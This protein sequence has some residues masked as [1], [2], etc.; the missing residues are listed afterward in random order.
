MV[1]DG[2]LNES[3]TTE[4][5]GD[6]IEATTTTSQLKELFETGELSKLSAIDAPELNI[7]GLAERLHDADATY[8]DGSPI[9]TKEADGSYTFNDRNPDAQIRTNTYVVLR[10]HMNSL[11]EEGRELLQSML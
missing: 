5:N 10:R 9:V 8:N 1:D 4:T 7:Q 6:G 11:S 2:Q 3:V